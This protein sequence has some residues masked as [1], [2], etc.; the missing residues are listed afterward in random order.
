MQGYYFPDVFNFDKLD[1][2]P[3]GEDHSYVHL[4]EEDDSFYVEIKLDTGQ[5]FFLLQFSFESNNSFK[6][7]KNERTT[8]TGMMHQ[9]LME[10]LDKDFDEE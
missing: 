4:F 1:G 2:F 8:K 7:L 10:E 6:F 5:S 9:K 3:V